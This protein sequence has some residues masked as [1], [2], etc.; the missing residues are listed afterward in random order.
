MTN[1]SL[2]L[3]FILILFAMPMIAFSE[4][5][6]KSEAQRDFEAMYSDE[7]EML[8]VAKRE[9]IMAEL[10]TLGEHPWAGVYSIWLGM[11]SKC[12]LIA[13]EAGFLYEEYGCMGV[14]GRDFGSVTQVNGTLVLEGAFIG[15]DRMDSQLTIVPWGERV[16]LIPPDRMLDFC[17][18]INRELVPKF[19]ME[20]LRQDEAAKL[21][22]EGW[23][24]VPA[25]YE[26]YLLPEPVECFILKVGDLVINTGKRVYYDREVDV[27][28]NKGAK[29]GLLPGMVLN[30][31]DWDY[32]VGIK[33]TII[34][35]EENT[36][37]GRISQTKEDFVLP[38]VGWGFTTGRR[39]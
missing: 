8:A 10:A 23:P 31:A 6:Q 12:L 16:Y 19:V 36:S 3:S 2:R 35:L 30:A 4:K 33:L 34:S 21:P 37:V 9:A 39:K 38:E 11:G 15:D 14:Y 22:V 28:L 17:N 27:T 29:A 18:M 7:A 26:G 1:L 20:F 24:L 32:G 13:P 5:V 25:E